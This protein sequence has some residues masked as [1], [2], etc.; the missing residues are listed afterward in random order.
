MEFYTITLKQLY[1]QAYQSSNRLHP[2]SQQDKYSTIIEKDI[3]AV[4][5]YHTF[6]NGPIRSGAYDDLIQ[7]FETIS[8]ET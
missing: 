1:E 4:N 3:E 8:I 7:L 2:P 5:A 6:A